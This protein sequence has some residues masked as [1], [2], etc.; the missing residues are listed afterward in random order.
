MNKKYNKT[1]QGV[2]LI[3]AL[4]LIMLMPGQSGAQDNA[5]SLKYPPSPNASNLGAYGKTKVSLYTGTPDISIPVYTVTDRS[6]SVP[7][8]L[9][10]NASGVRPN[11]KTSWVGL[12]WNLMCGGV[13]TREVKGAYHDEVV[14]GDGL[15]FFEHPESAYEIAYSEN[16]VLVDKFGNT[17]V[18]N[19]VA[20]YYRDYDT[21]PDIFYYNF[22]GYSGK[23][24]RNNNTQPDEKHFETV[25]YQNFSINIED[26]INVGQEYIYQ[27]I[28][29]D[30][31]GIKYTFGAPVQ[32]INNKENEEGV[33]FS[34]TQPTTSGGN[35][36]YQF[37]PTAWYLKEIESPTGDLI[38]FYYSS[39][40]ASGNRHY[41]YSS[42]PFYKL[43]HLYESSEAQWFFGILTTIDTY[44]CWNINNQ[45]IVS[46]S[47]CN[48]LD[49]IET[50]KEKL[51]FQRSNSNF[52][53]NNPGISNGEN[54]YDQKLDQI[55]I[56]DKKSNIVVKTMK[57]YYNEDGTGN[58]LR[59]D[60][61]QRCDKSG[62][63]KAAYDFTY[64]NFNMLP[65]SS[66][67][68]I[69]AGVFSTIFRE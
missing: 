39:R 24:F 21:E 20:A 63:G 15:G 61:F 40:D 56:K 62:S 50:S 17:T 2:F 65:A 47:I 13:I 46:Y 49:S 33:E 32:T 58:R 53:L 48:Y 38:T 35:Y 14:Y 52:A 66:T 30:G 12:N 25:P 55:V 34:W 10:Y 60:R 26:G 67:D 28:I 9:N 1:R 27:I 22:C 41:S 37:L 8:S 64:K 5:I 23:F 45:D 54:R 43:E 6:L 19:P 16:D 4:L 36:N 31:N 68:K 18:V 51:I 69:D 29:R 42:N 7:I 3:A 57:L 44:E 59:L 11:M